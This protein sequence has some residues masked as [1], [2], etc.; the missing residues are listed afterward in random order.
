[1]SE[2]LEW[3]ASKIELRRPTYLITANLDFAEKASR[4]VELHRIFIEADLVICD[5]TPLIWAS[6]L[7]GTP[8]RERVAG[9][10]LVPKIA[11]RSAKEGW[12]IFLLGGDPQSLASAEENLK[13]QYPGIIISGSFS[14]PF[15]PLYEMD[16]DEI[17][18]RIKKS[19]P[20]ILLVAFGCPKQ[21]KWIS[22]HYKD[23]G[24]PCSIGVG[25]TIDFIAGK[26]L[27]APRW[28][29]LFGLEWVFRLLQEPRRLLG[30]YYHD[31][32]FL[33]VQLLRERNVF[34]IPLSKEKARTRLSLDEEKPEIIFWE[35]PL[36]AGNLSDLGEPSFFKQFVI[37]LSG[38][39]MVDSSGLG[40][41]LQTLRRAL[42][43][44]V[45]GCFSAPSE[46][47]LKILQLTRLDRV[48]PI[49]SSLEIAL[50]F[51]ARED[52]ALIPQPVIDLSDYSMQMLMPQGL[53]KMNVSECF[54]K[55]SE[56]WKNRPF[57]KTLRLD[58][59]R[60]H[61]LDSAGLGMIV[62]SH[63][64]VQRR[65]SCELR[66]LNLSPNVLNVIRIAR[67]EKLLAL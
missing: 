33:F 9:S 3:I 45:T 19:A 60:T 67:L 23:L 30:R 50:G 46:N 18:Q 16:H 49:H 21:E 2:T 1:M 44:G 40:H 58:F 61:V 25:A 17:S 56:E 35:G 41:L 47:V 15:S 27:R 31:F 4:D 32:I 20:D 14:P 12:K 52:S 65:E 26:V 54:Q 28:I 48:V 59:E 57:L 55:I 24:V 34:L 39:T 22:E 51:L 29:G 66:L 36:L 6:R 11:E 38:V 53:T 42:A 63:R 62:D 7:T 5:G 10:D 8:L 64:M 43:Q 37:D 13:K